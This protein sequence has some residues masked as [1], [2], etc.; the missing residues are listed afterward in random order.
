MF[1]II[2]MRA[3]WNPSKLKARLHRKW[4]PDVLPTVKYRDSVMHVQGLTVTSFWLYRN[5][6]LDIYGMIF[7][8]PFA[9]SLSFLIHI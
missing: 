6:I 5:G 2:P 4:P 8:D 7:Y 1:T 3:H 9:S